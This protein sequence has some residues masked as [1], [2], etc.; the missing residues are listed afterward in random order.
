MDMRSASQAA[1]VAA[2]GDIALQV[3]WRLAVGGWRLVA[4]DCPTDVLRAHQQRSTTVR[5]LGPFI[6]HLQT[7]LPL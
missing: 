6:K 7:S 4:S 5:L 1:Q 3:G 2:T